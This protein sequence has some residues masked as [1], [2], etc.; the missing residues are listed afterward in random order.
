MVVDSKQR[1]VGVTSMPLP[2]SSNSE[3]FLWFG[4]QFMTVSSVGTATPHH[5][6][7]GMDR[8]EVDS[9]AMRKITLNQSLVLVSEIA[10]LDGTAGDVDFAINLRML[11]KK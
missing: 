11:F 3:D 1:A 9:K 4:S 8:L 10:Q 7:Y 6:S 5:T 2:L